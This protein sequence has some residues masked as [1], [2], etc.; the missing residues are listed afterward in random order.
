LECQ[1]N[2][3][4]IGEI[5]PALMFFLFPLIKKSLELL[6]ATRIFYDYSSELVDSG[7]LP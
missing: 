5:I 3:Q 6:R 7:I 4:Y 2:S 1:R